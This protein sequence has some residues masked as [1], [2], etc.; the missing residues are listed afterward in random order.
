[1]VIINIERTR[2]GRIFDNAIAAL[3]AHLHAIIT[4]SIFRGDVLVLYIF[5][6]T[7]C[8]TMVLALSCWLFTKFPRFSGC[9]FIDQTLWGTV[10][11][12][13]KSRGF[14]TRNNLSLDLTFM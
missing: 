12:E 4:Y 7:V 3:I 5:T 1:M 9:F 10:Q 13:R 8:I 6:A 2:T 11:R 14:T